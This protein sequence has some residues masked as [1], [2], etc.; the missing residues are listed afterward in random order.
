MLFIILTV[1][2][3]DFSSLILQLFNTTIILMNSTQ[4][5]ISFVITVLYALQNLKTIFKMNCY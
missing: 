4:R 5:Y 3:K 2:K 1:S